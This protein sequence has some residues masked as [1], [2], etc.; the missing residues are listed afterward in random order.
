VML[1]FYADWCVSCK[2]F[3]HFTLPD[4]KVRE[5]L[6]GFLLLQ[7]DVTANSPE[8]QALLKQFGLFG[9][10]AILF[11]P[12]GQSSEV[13]RV[14]GFENAER[15]SASLDLVRSRVGL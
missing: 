3:E 5:R 15:F 2:E 10:P 1:D 14:I 9:P 8:D 6:E 13:F 4:A 12:A 11:F 7:V